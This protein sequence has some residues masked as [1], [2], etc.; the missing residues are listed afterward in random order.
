M[1][2]V[3]F[4]LIMVIFI[5]AKY[6]LN[7]DEFN[8]I[9]ADLKCFI[10]SFKSK[11]NFYISS[12]IQYLNILNKLHNELN[13][14]IELKKL[15]VKIKFFPKSDHSFYIGQVLG[16]SRFELNEKQK[17]TYK[18]NDVFINISDGLFHSKILKLNNFKSFVFNYSIFEKKITEIKDL[19]VQ[20]IINLK[21]AGLKKFYMSKNIGILVCLKNGQ[22][23]NESQ[24]NE[25]IKFI[26]KN[27][28]VYYIFLSDYIDFKEF[29]N[30]NF[31]D[32]W[33]NTACSRLSYDDAMENE[34][35]FPY[36]EDLMVLEN[37]KK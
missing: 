13:K 27:K 30:F 6:S 29:D 11:N 21:K 14:D 34:Q 18:Q 37:E 33:I 32:L 20:K 31:I 15:S 22:M 9:Y 16:C 36:Y 17:E 25:L 1:F 5:E 2:Y 4:I 24:L 35:V 10:L 12:S 26:E 3:I 28:K 19:D 8:Q 23:I 7:E